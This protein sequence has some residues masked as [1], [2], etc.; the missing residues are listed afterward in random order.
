MHDIADVGQIFAGLFLHKISNKLLM[1]LGALAYTVAFVLMALNRDDSS[2]WAFLFP[3][4]TI[5]VIG[6][7]L[8]FNVCQMYVMSSMTSEQQA[9]AGGI[10]QTAARLFS[11]IGFGV[12]TALFKAI[13]QSPATSGYYAHQAIAPYSAVFWFAAAASAV[14]LVLVAFLRLGTQGETKHGEAE[15]YASEIALGTESV[16]AKRVAKAIVGQSGE[17]AGPSE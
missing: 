12:A 17:E 15:E 16:Q 2:Y 6:A 5:C 10:F 11:T 7:D 13:E 3:A 1:G 4:F 8:E 9:L 14:S